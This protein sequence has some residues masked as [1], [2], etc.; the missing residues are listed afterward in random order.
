MMPLSM[1]DPAGKLTL[2][3]LLSSSASSAG[4][5]VMA[6]IPF[7]MDLP[8]GVTLSGVD[9]GD[10]GG[11]AVVLLHGLTD[12]WRS[13]ELVLPHLPPS[14]R[15]VAVSQRGHGDSSKP[16][17]GYRVRDFAADLIAVLDKL[18]IERAVVVGH[19]S[20]GLVAQRFAIDHSERTSG[21]VLESAFATLRG[22]TALET[23]V[24]DRI[25]PLRDPID[26]AFVRKFQTGTFLRRVPKPFLD[27]MVAETL[28]VPAR[29]WREAFEALLQE[30]LT[31]EVSA[32]AVPT[33]LIGGTGDALV[34]PERQQALASAIPAATLTL[35][36]GVGHSPHWENP[37]RFAADLAAFVARV[38]TRP[39]KP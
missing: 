9:Q 38:A 37:H 20:H 32:I 26:P 4:L 18:E 33:L 27:A 23:F 25:S 12:S 15:A 22:N 11:P 14:I 13:F 39:P 10:T 6:A 16:D 8:N 5:G 36:D 28:K 2:W 1:L 34:T 21:I 19:S 35:Y 7:S 29:V 3:R 30:D 17:S 24:R 31:S